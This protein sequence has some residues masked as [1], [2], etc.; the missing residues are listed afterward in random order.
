MAVLKKF[1][2]SLNQSPSKILI[3]LLLLGL[4][5]RLIG[6]NFG[7]PFLY[8]VDEA[9]FA[10]ISLKYF[11]GDLNP[12]FFHVPS[13]YT[14]LQA[15]VWGIFYLLG[16]LLGFFSSLEHFISSFQ[17]NPTLFIL[18]G[19][20]INL[21]FSLGTIALVFTLGRKIYSLRAGFWAALLLIF[22]H[23]HN[24]ISHYSLPDV[25]MVFFLV[26]TFY[27]IWELYTKGQARSYL[28]AGLFAGL[29]TATKY[30]GQLLFLPLFLAH[31]D[32][33][34]RQKHSWRTLL[35]HPP[36]W[37]AGILFIMAFLAGCPFSLLDFQ[38]FWKDFQWQ[39]QHL[40]TV[41]HYGGALHQSAFLFYLFYGFRENIGLIAQW[42]LPLGLLLALKQRNKNDLL[43][44]SYPLLMFIIVATW[45]AKAVR[46]LLPFI[47]FLIIFCGKIMDQ[48]L[49]FWEQFH[50]SLPFPHLSIKIN[51]RLIIGVIS[52]AVILPQA[53]KVTR[54][55]LSLTQKDT[56]TLAR[57]WIL[58]HLPPKSTIALEMYGPPLFDCDYHL[59]Y[60]HTLGN[61][62]LEW[63]AFRQVEFIIISD[64]MYQRFVTNP[65]EYP[66]QAAFYQS[67]EEKAV[68]IKEFVPSWNEELIDLHNPTI[69]IYRL[70][71]LPNYDFP[72]NFR[73]YAQSITLIKTSRL[74][75]QLQTTAISL[76][77][78][79][80]QEKVTQPFI[81]IRSPKGATRAK[82]YLHPLPSLN[83]AFPRKE[84]SGQANQIEIKPQDELYIGYEYIFDPAPDYL[85]N[86]GPYEKKFRL[87]KGFTSESLAKKELN[88]YFF[89][90]QSPGKNGDEYFQIVTITPHRKNFR[91]FSQIYGGELRWGDDYL[92]NPFAQ[93]VDNQGRLLFKLSLF[94]GKIGSSQADKRGP[95]RK[96]MGIPPLSSPF[97]IQGGFTF[98]YDNQRPEKAGGPVLF[99]FPSLFSTTE[100]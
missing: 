96:S 76:Y 37:G 18:I 53:Y 21:I 90:R 14:Y 78:S 9:R 12:H 88:I 25:P 16:K 71:T 83:T 79:G 75:W 58:T 80:S 35:F 48:I 39:S 77:P 20:L 5:T 82:I 28:L 100:N 41:G 11:S 29:A 3:F 60:R 8:H 1:P 81:E 10:Q 27:F 69:K 95:A 33:H 55:D 67:L 93:I 57:E 30:G 52:L 65:Q 40:Y 38:T 13:F 32:Y 74:Q 45:K 22:S 50:S 89:Y 44:L 94:E 6:L 72:G 7:L 36:L 34:R 70:S 56:R 63:L 19:R 98:Y 86:V 26:L 73:Q 91:F 92:V 24:K 99:S 68:L 15:G 47:P 42:L 51:R 4:I 17:A 64:I 31:Y 62:N 87:T 59:L 2:V 43:L 97:K 84:Y 54:F 46:Y 49:S 66:K 61:V 23:I 85:Q